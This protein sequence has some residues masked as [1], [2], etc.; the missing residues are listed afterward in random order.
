MQPAGAL[1]SDARLHRSNQLLNEAS[2]L[3]EISLGDWP[4][5]DWDSGLH[6]ALVGN[7]VATINDRTQLRLQL[8]GTLRLRSRGGPLLQCDR[9]PELN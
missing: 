6:V 5:R 8:L 1:G 3:S 7:L 9:I 2:D 4:G